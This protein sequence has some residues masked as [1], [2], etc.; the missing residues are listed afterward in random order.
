[1][2]NKPYLE[3]ITKYNIAL[4]KKKQFLSIN[5]SSSNYQLGQILQRLGFG[6]LSVALDN[7]TLLFRLT[8][9]RAYKTTRITKLSCS[10]CKSRF[11]SKKALNLL[12]INSPTSNLV[13]ATPYGLLTNQEAVALKS[14]G[15][16]LFKFS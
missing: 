13:L 8:Y 4:K 5:N 14:G 7:Q 11:L 12:L 1:M 16:V 10:S 9:T 2:E 3:F 6:S 15:S